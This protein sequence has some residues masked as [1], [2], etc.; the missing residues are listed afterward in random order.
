[1]A[2]ENFD[3]LLAL[4]P[5]NKEPL[6]AVLAGPENENMLQ[7]IF[8]AAKAGIVHPVL[9]GNRDHTLALLDK[10]G[11]AGE[12]YTM[13]SA[14]HSVANASVDVVRSGEGDILM[15]GE[16]LSHNFLVP[17]VNGK[18]GLRRGNEFM[19]HVTLAS[20]PEYPRLLGLADMAVIIDP[21]VG[22]K[23][24]IIRNTVHALK[25]LGYEKP[26]LAMMA[27]V[28]K[29]T[30]QME[31]T[32]EA[33]SLVFEQSRRP[34]ADCEL[35]GPISYDLIVSKESA[36]LKNYECPYTGGGFD[37]IIAPELTTANTLLKSWTIHAEATVCG[38]VIGAQVP[39]ALTSRFV[40]PKEAFLSLAFCAILDKYYKEIGWKD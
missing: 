5:K 37:A 30:F 38:A 28:E 7:G 22:L 18:H 16:M 19:S 20:L 35:W 15:R 10:L 4:V 14:D 39:I 25:A 21:D 23:R 2:L 9:V 3:Q 24:T 12:P 36:R 17:V 6:K 34:I 33:Q 13:I 31:D 1:M 40:A 11:L 26:V 8:M 32:V 29:G 27:L